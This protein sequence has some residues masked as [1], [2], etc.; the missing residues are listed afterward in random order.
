MRKAAARLLFVF[1][2]LSGM[3]SSLV[4]ADDTD[5]DVTFIERLPRYDY[6][7]AQNNP[8]PGDTVTFNGHIKHWGDT[9]LTEVDYVWFM[10]GTPVPVDTLTN[11][12]PGE[13]RVVTWQWTWE[14]GEHTIKLVVDPENEIAELSEENNVVEDRTDA[15]IVGFWVEQ[16]V[17]DYF[18]QYQ[19]ELGDGANSW[20]DW[21]QRQIRR[22]NEMNAAAVWPLS[23]QGVLDRFRLDKIVVVS[24]G[25]LPL[26]PWGYATNNPD[27]N[28]KTV[29]LMWG[30]PINPDMETFYA[31][32]TTTDGVNP[33]HIEQSLLHELGHAR[34]LIDNYGFDVHN[35]ASHHA[36]QIYEGDTYV[37]GSRYMPFLAYDEVLYYNTSG[38]VM[39]GPY[40]F[41]WSPYEAAAL[42]R[43][44][45]Q[46][47]IC[48]NYN[49]PCNI[50][51]FLQDL[52]EHNHMRFVDK[53]GQPL[54]GAA[55]GIYNAVGGP[56]W[57]GKT[58]DNSV[59]QT[60]VADS[61]GYVHL[62]RNPFNPGGDIIHTYEN[63]NGLMV[64][65]IAY[66]GHVWYRFQDVTDFNLQYW[67]GNTEDAYYTIAVDH[68]PVQRCPPS[69]M[70]ENNA[71]DWEGWAEE[72][73]NWQSYFEDDTTKTAPGSSGSA[74]VK[75][76]TDGGW[77]TYIR[78]PGAYEA[79]WDLS[80]VDYLYISFYAENPSPNDFQ[81]GPV[82]RLIDG[83]GNY[84]EYNYYENGGV[85]TLLNDAV[86]RWIA[87]KVPLDAPELPDDG[88]G[89]IPVITDT[90]D[91]SNI[92]YL[93]IHA[94]TWD[95]GF[96]LWIDDVSFDPAMPC[97][98][99]DLDGD[100][101]VDGSDLAELANCPTALD[102]GVFASGFGT[103]I[104]E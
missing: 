101:D 33:F 52:P 22:W 17:Y 95:N 87:L 61:D 77:D 46:R 68:V 9:E 84:Y 30:F 49:A 64:L 65:R 92:R 2:F 55:I 34:Y 103:E 76:V 71:A 26:G 16:S 27:V 58:I 67:Q 37:A 69:E 38:G 89:R 99:A 31:D 43:I 86:G 57:Y 21:A 80:G 54:P 24:D 66:G 32:H 104:C 50:G 14:S 75:F 93:E 7:A 13:E 35:S 56:G 39:T 85:K 11:L 41:A 47:A 79:R 4:L 15:L 29:D 48:G 8:E 40:G 60:Y 90:P 1:I 3:C 53:S 20:E 73:V 96:T 98:P 19:H 6:D 51:E 70:A 45:G 36:V 82:I 18:H 10:D 42:N 94:D 28:D 72:P 25:A 100:G 63:A 102:W 91:L 81:Q 78:Y 12:Q 88:W 97:C 5:L 62:P 59:D 74:S 83:N 23:P 44:A